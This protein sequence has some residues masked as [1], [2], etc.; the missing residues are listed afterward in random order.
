[1]DIGRGLTKYQRVA[2]DNDP[3][4]LAGH[5]TTPLP[6]AVGVVTTHVGDHDHLGVNNVGGVEA[7]SNPTST[8][9]AST[10]SL[11]NHK[12]AAAVSNSK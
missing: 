2:L 4:L 12:R 5:S 10:A 8:S 1:M 11:L 9:A 3:G 7:A 6:P